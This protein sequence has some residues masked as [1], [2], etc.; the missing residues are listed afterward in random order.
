[1]EPDRDRSPD[2]APARN[3]PPPVPAAG[4][5]PPPVVT[6]EALLAGG[7]ELVIWHGA[8]AYRLRVTGNNK[9]ILTK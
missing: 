9:L 5:P 7:R 1:M 2:A 3:G 6:S 8:E 4:A